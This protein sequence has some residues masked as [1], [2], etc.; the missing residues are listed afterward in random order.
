MKYV[1]HDKILFPKPIFYSMVIKILPD[2]ISYLLATV[3]SHSFHV[4]I[5]CILA[6]WSSLDQFICRLIVKFQVQKV[7]KR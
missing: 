4:S 2:T 7:T 1:R 3:F 5:Y 6:Q